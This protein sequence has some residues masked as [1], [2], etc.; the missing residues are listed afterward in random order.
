MAL[1]TF[2]GVS[3]QSTLMQ[4]PRRDYGRRSYTVAGGTIGSDTAQN[5]IYSDGTDTFWQIRQ[6]I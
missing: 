5:N 3:I 2:G 6:V 1:V 4:R